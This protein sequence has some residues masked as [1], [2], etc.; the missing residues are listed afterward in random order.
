M[1]LSPSFVHLTDDLHVTSPIYQNA[2]ILL[3]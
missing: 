1:I 2:T 3:A